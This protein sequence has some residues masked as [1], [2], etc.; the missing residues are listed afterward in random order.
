MTLYGL[1]WVQICF[2]IKATLL[3]TVIIFVLWRVAFKVLPLSP[4]ASAHIVC[5][6]VAIMAGIFFYEYLAECSLFMAILAALMYLFAFITF[7]WL[8]P[9]NV[10]RS[11]TFNILCY[12]A[13]N[14]GKA[15]KGEVAKMLGDDDFYERYRYNSLEAGG[16]IKRPSRNELVITPKGKLVVVTHLAVGKLCGVENWYHIWKAKQ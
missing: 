12:L 8:S 16:F 11:L 4:M 14:G 2:F 7:A 3:F 6:I 10:E 5:V 15:L 13:G 9:L 1:F